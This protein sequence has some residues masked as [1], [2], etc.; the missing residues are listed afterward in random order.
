MNKN[1]SRRSFVTGATGAGAFAA[2]AGLAGCNNPK[3]DDG[4]QKASG[5]KK[6]KLTMVPIPAVSMTSPLTSPLGRA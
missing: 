1:V 5:E 4:G 3:K 6:K 2:L